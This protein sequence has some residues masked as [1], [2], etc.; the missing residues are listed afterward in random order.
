[1]A[2]PETEPGPLSR[3]V[4]MFYAGVHYS[5]RLATSTH[6]ISRYRCQRTKPLCAY[7]MGSHRG[8]ERHRHRL[9]SVGYFRTGGDG[10][11][12]TAAGTGVRDRS[13]WA[14]LSQERGGSATRV[15]TSTRERQPIRPRAELITRT[16]KISAED[17]WR[18][19]ADPPISAVLSTTCATRIDRG[20]ERWSRS[21]ECVPQPRPELR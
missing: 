15:T 9:T 11:I 4:T 21:K 7:E 16:I 5:H 18:P 13:G 8:Y 20:G 12:P 17:S 2:E 19:R 1:V 3:S 10:P 6:F 14:H